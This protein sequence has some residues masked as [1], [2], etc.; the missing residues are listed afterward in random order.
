MNPQALE[1]NEIIQTNSN[2]TFTLLSHKGKRIFFPKKGILAQTAQAKGK[3][4]NATIGAAVEDDGSPMRLKSIEKELNID[5]SLSFPYAPSF[6]R[7]DLRKKWKELLVQKNPTL[8]SKPFSNPIVTNA[9][10]HGLSICGYLFVD[11][12][13]SIIMPNPYWGNYNLTFQNAYDAEFDKFPLFEKEGVNIAGFKEKL[14]TGHIG[15]K[16]LLLN[17]PN[18]P[19]GY[20]PKQ[21]E[22]KDICEIILQSAKLG[23]TIVVLIDDAYFG[24]VYEDG[25]E[26]ESFF[27]YLSDL[28]ENVLAVKIDGATKEDYVWGFRVGFLTFGIKGGNNSLYEALEAKTAG[29]IRGNIS[30]ASNLSQSLVLGAYSSKTYQ[31]E[32]AEKNMILNNRYKKVKDALKKEKYA[33]VFQPLPFNS[34]YFMCVQLNAVLDEEKIRQILL[35]EFDTGVISLP[36]MLRVAYSA[37]AEHDIEEL[38]E[39]IYNACIKSKSL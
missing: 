2:A 18:N 5:P 11:P 13:D 23:N 21:Q 15:K 6:G 34:G 24:L 27:S 9:L 7:P 4:I 39:N 22:V 36:N 14:M 1:L 10:T 31:K 30:N 3:R 35:D 12:G 38:F 19:T 8:A 33:E 17:F 28:H 32:K 25:I 26:K 37:V 29:A 16:L 20:T